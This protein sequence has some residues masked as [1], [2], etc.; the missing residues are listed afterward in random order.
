MVPTHLSKGII[1]VGIILAWFALFF[2]SAIAMISAI[3]TLLVILLRLYSFQNNTKQVIEGIVCHREVQANFIRV[4]SSVEVRLSIGISVPGCFRVVLREKVSPG[5]VIQKGDLEFSVTGEKTEQFELIYI[6]A[7]MVHG[8]LS[9]PGLAIWITDSFFSDEIPLQN[10]H[11]NGPFLKVFPSGNYELSLESY[12]YGE[13]EIERIRARSGIELSGFRQYVPGD[14]MKHIDWKMTAKYG[15]P[16][17][18]QYTGIGGT[19]PLI[20]L[21]LPEQ[22]ENAMPVHFQTMVRA[23]SGAIEESWKK[24]R[25]S[26]FVLISGPNIIESSRPGGGVEQSLAILNASAYPLKRARTYYRFQTKGA[27]RAINGE[28]LKVRCVANNNLDAQEYLENIGSI[29]SSFQQDPQGVPAFHR[30]IAQLHKMWPHDTVI[31]FSLCSGDISHIGYIIEQVHYDNGT[32][33]LHVPSNSVTP[34][35]MRICLHDGVDMVRVF[36]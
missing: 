25:K 19:N 20:I 14:D 22:V 27:L 5:M 9:F 16:V 35:F 2:N 26:S 36:S 6:A 17:V 34:G 7:P 1:I 31:I 4:G 8:I 15:K 23:V 28:I 12:E 18:R 3:A 13:Q 32:V 11:F 24:Y 21:D 33:Q 30:E 29:I 10:D